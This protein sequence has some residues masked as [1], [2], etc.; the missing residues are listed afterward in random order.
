MRSRNIKP[1]FFK[2][3]DLG[4]CKFEE[5]ILFIGLWCMADREGFFENRPPKIAVEV[6]PYDRK[7]DADHI[8]SMLCNLMSL[9]LI[10]LHEMYGY[11]P[12]FL[13]HQNP[14]PHEAKC[15]VPTDIQNILKNQCHCKPCNDMKCNADILNPDI[16]NPDTINTDC[17]EVLDHLNLKTGKKFTDKSFILSRLKEGKTKEQLLQIIDNQIEDPYF[18]ENPKFLN[19]QTLFRPI[20]FDKYLNNE[21]VKKHQISN[22]HSWGNELPH[23]N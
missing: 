16:L 5:R 20:H 22:P 7:I 13:K 10:T 18:K 3:E 1:G 6:F 8:K 14:H 2:N 12:N 9:H 4:E 19:P 21:P 11:I 17:Q 23:E 15:T